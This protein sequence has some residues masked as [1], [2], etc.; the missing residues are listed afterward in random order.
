MLES[1]QKKETVQNLRYILCGALMGAGAIL[2]GVSGG[3]LAVIFGVYRPMM[4]LLTDPRQMLPRYWR[5]IPPLIL[6]WVIGFWGLAKGIALCLEQSAIVTTWL[7]IGLIAGTLPALLREA[8]GK[9]GRS[10]YVDWLSLL[11]CGCFMFAA[12]FYIEHISEISVVPN[13]WWYNFCGALWGLSI[14][15][16]G[17]TSSSIMMSLGLYQPM[18]DGLAS[19]DW[20]MMLSC[21]P[22]FVLT[23]LLFARAANWLF[24]RYNKIAAHGIIGIV[25]ASTLMIIPLPIQNYQGSELILSL[26]CG[27]G[28]LCLALVLNRLNIQN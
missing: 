3:V 1:L 10:S 15:I 16:P 9:D 19:L 20:N 27:I 18:L 26:L 24:T 21:I 8:A 6:G 22:G 28:G 23:I 12:L 5:L 25:L 13:F 4:E 14:V 17:L 2:P 11:L 7:F